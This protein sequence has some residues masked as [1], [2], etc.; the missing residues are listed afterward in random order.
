MVEKP[1]AELGGIKGR[2]CQVHNLCAEA[3]PNDIGMPVGSRVGGEA[4]TVEKRR[5]VSEV[6][7]RSQVHYRGI[8]RIFRK[9]IANGVFSFHD[10]EELSED[11]RKKATESLV[12]Y[13]NG[14]RAISS[15]VIEYA[16]DDEVS[17]FPFR[18]RKVRALFP[19]I[20]AVAFVLLERDE[21]L[22]LSSEDL[23]KLKESYFAVK[24]IKKRIYETDEFRREGVHFVVKASH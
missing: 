9:E 21:P 7:V 13:I 15:R 6:L 16:E 22:P 19:M 1:N 24:N 12:E 4:W 20:E 18:D 11:V 10:S 14:F 2:C 23:K 17:Y 5:L 8:H 3:S